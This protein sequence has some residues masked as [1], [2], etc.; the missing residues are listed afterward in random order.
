MHEDPQSCDSM[1]GANRC[2]PQRVKQYG[3][4]FAFFNILFRRK[5]TL[6][7][8]TGQEHVLVIT[9]AVQFK[10]HRTSIKEHPYVKG[11]SA[12]KST[13]AQNFNFHDFK[14]QF[15]NSGHNGPNYYMLEAGD[16][17]FVIRRW[18]TDGTAAQP[19]PA[20]RGAVRSTAWRNGGSPEG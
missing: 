19:A 12:S 14:F 13:L 9:L 15:S 1:F 6:S 20:F 16:P 8:W 11:Q 4:R 7:T 2:H 17:I 10:C 5:Q 18:L 3:T